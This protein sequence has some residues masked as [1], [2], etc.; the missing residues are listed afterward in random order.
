M[1]GV[2]VRIGG[3]STDFEAKANRVSSVASGMAKSLAA[4]LAGYLS[5]RAVIDFT[6]SM[7]AA[8]DQI[9]KGSQKLQVSTDTYQRL[10]RAAE[11]AGSSIDTVEK[12][13]K[14]MNNMIDDAGKGTKDAIDTLG[15]LGFTYEKLRNMN[16]EERFRA[17]ATAI[18]EVVNEGDRAA[19]AND[20]FGRGG[21]ELM[22]LVNAYDGLRE[23]VS[24][25]SDEAVA[26]SAALTD[27]ILRLNAAFA[28]MAANTGVISYLQDVAEEMENI[29]ALNEKSDRARKDEDILTAY[30]GGLGGVV[31]DALMHMG[32]AGGGLGAG[33]DPSTTRMLQ[34]SA[35][36]IGDEVKK[37]KQ[38]KAARDAEKLAREEVRQKQASKDTEAA[39]ENEMGRVT[40]EEEKAAIA[41]AK[42]ATDQQRILDDQAQMIRLQELLN[43]KKEREAAIEDALYKAKQKNLDLSDDQLGAVA[44]QAGRLFDLR[45]GELPAERLGRSRADVASTS[46]ERIGA[47]FGGGGG[48]E[49]RLDTIAEQSKRQNSWLE[50]IYV[51]TGDNALGAV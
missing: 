40:A 41:T 3:D 33:T 48:A 9:D 6:R 8:G 27:S 19:L 49:G 14:A 16:A 5:T 39:I 50:K 34:Y 11:I 51:K 32:F 46:L 2:T 17:I 44:E 12:S 25:M 45:Q 37:K 7:V 22:P 13:F 26:A 24:M 31:Q 38:E 35:L 23:G 29:A 1:S 10:K 43:D 21:Q 18:K 30:Q 36:D 42:K 4:P 28:A 20:I 47:V 15:R